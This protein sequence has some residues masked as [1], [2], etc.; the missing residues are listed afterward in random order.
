MNEKVKRLA[1]TRQVEAEYKAELKALRAEIAEE[2]GP[3]I[4][5]IQGYIDTAHQDV[6]WAEADVRMM[7]LGEFERS[8]NKH[9]HPAASVRIYTVLDYS[10]DAAIGYCV[11]HN[12]GALRLD[13]KAFEKAAKK[14]LEAMDEG[15]D[16]GDAA[17]DLDGLVV[18]GSD[19]RVAIKRDLSEYL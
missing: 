11:R 1:Y 19:P 10:E 6:S 2:Y 17:E 13:K 8:G 18:I 3:T 7:A 9:P 12:Q 16:L 15:V 14:I 4:K 5:R